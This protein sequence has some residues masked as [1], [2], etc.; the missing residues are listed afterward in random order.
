VVPG[1]G[2]L[3]TGTIK[4]KDGPCGFVVNETGDAKIERGMVFFLKISGFPE[5]S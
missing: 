3:K 2:T 5:L 4:V 1:C